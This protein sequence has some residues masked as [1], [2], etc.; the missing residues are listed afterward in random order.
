M[1]DVTQ[2]FENM[3]RALALIRAHRRD[4]KRRGPQDLADLGMAL[5]RYVAPNADVETRAAQ[6]GEL[7]RGQAILANT[8]I[9]AIA[10]SSDQNAD[11]IL[12]DY[13][14]HALE[15]VARREQT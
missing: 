12:E 13:E 11:D 14:D 9:E 4:L 15:M 8:L 7:I 10:S 3:E 2:D 5:L 6:F 1:T